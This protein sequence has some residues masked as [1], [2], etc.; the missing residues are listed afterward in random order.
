MTMA[1]ANAMAMHRRHTTAK[2]APLDDQRLFIFSK[3]AFTLDR[4]PDEGHTSD[5]SILPR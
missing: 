2:R 3:V 5:R 1:I 4:G